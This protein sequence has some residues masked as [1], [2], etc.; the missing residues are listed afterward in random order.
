MCSVELHKSDSSNNTEGTILDLFYCP[1]TLH[2]TV[3]KTHS[4]DTFHIILCL[5]LVCV[6]VLFFSQISELSTLVRYLRMW[7]FYHCHIQTLVYDVFL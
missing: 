4:D 5:S 6:P 2:Q 3:S 1:L 7:Q